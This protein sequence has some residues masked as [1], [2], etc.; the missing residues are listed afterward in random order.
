MRVAPAAIQKGILMPI[1]WVSAALKLMTL[2]C[3]FALCAAV[4]IGSTTQATLAQGE[5]PKVAKVIF[6]PLNDSG[7]AG[8]ATLTAKGD[9]TVVRIRADG[10]LGNHPTH[11]HQGRCEDLDPNP[12]I[13]LT[14]VQLQPTSMSGT[15]NTTIDMQLADLLSE[16]RLILIHK[17]Q[18]DIGAYLACGNITAG[19]LTDEQR[20]TGGGDDPLP[21]TGVGDLTSGSVIPNAT[22][23][24]LSTAAAALCLIMTFFHIR[25]NPIRT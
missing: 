16:D 3:A 18:K 2:P 7:I 8:Y 4:F 6:E 1:A 11:I 15:S 17:S 13:P 9:R 24:M 12:E 21:N 25:R 23:L 14:N 22:W 20:A 5:E 19:K 10:A